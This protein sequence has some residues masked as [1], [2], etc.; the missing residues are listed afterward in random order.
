MAGLTDEQLLAVAVHCAKVAVAEV[1]NASGP[2]DEDGRICHPYHVGRLSAALETL[3][4][5]L[6]DPAA[7]P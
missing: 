6:G 7:R 1:R 2:L 4:K 3:L 5:A